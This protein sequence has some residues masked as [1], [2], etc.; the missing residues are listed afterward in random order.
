MQII[1]TVTI[2]FNILYAV[3]IL[4]FLRPLKWQNKNDRFSIVAFIG[5]VVL[6]ASNILCMQEF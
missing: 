4:S 5:M 6:F 2:I 3:A 1:K